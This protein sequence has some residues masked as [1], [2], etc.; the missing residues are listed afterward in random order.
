MR[1]AGNQGWLGY[2]LNIHPTQSLDEVVAALRGPVRTVKRRLCPD[3]PFAVGLRLSAEAAHTPDAAPIL[4][5]IFTEENYHAYTMNGFPYGR[6]HGVP[7]KK[8]VYEP[9]WTMPERRAY[10]HSLARIM[11]HLIPPGA[12]ATISTVPGGF[13]PALKDRHR[14]VAHGLLTCVCDLVLLAQ[15]TDR[16]VALALEPEPWCLLDQIDEAVVF[17]KTH[18]FTEEAARTVAAATG[19]SLV[20]AAA[21]IPR[22]LGLCLDACHLAVGFEDPLASLDRLSLAGIAIHKL[23]LSAA[24]RVARIDDTAR[25]RLAAFTDPTYLHQ[26]VA[27]TKNGTVRRFLDLPDALAAPKADEDEEWR[28]HFHVPLFAEPT[29]PLASTRDSLATLLRRH[30]DRPITQHLEIETYTWDVLPSALILS[31]ME[32][33]SGRIDITQSIEKEFQWVA[34][35]LG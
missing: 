6:F 10:T 7:V 18:L 22:H 3:R 21:S 34:A 26:V 16:V 29:P 2:C 11:A 9:D 28:V 30:R 5:A 31:D 13:A 33:S 1:L 25:N 14:A 15:A 32:P 27:R 4:A 20:D 19:L 17:F 23:Q 35:Q 24:L 12:H 8:T